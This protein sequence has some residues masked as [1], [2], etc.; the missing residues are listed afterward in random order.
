VASP[1]SLHEFEGASTIQRNGLLR[2]AQPSNEAAAGMRA[3]VSTAF[4]NE[5]VMV[6]YLP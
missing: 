4:I 6:S 2:N 3:N 1:S 5:G